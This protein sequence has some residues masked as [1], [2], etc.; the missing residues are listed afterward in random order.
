MS[1]EKSKKP[2]KKTLR[3]VL[4]QVLLIL[5]AVAFAALTF[6]VRTG[7]SFAID[8]QIARALQSIDSPAFAVLMSWVSWPGF[9]PQAVIITLLLALLIFALGLHWEAIA[10]LAAALFSTA[11]NILVQDWVRRPRPAVGVVNVIETLDSY[12]FPSRHVM[13][14]V[15]F[16]GFMAFL[17]YTLMKPS[18]QRALL[19]IFFGGLVLLVGPSRIFLGQHWP[20]DVLAGYLLG[21]LIL[22]FSIQFYRWGKKR[23]FVHQPA[24]GTASQRA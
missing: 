16:F 23:F 20:S 11:V 22:V 14:Y 10:A 18:V 21:C 13:F 6:L 19:L 2:V 5:V 15:S 9:G 17:A 3:A 4:F 24:A 7:P 1:A 12:S 8:L